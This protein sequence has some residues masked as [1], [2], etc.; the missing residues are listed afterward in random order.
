MKGKIHR[1]V[2]RPALMYGLEAAPL[3]RVEEKML[4]VAEMRMLWWIVVVTRINR[5]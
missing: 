3:R 4:D 1:A 5:V 2:V